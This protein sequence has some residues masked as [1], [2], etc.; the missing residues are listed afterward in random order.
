MRT[1]GVALAGA[2]AWSR[3]Y[4]NYHTPK[5]VGVGCVAGVVS[6]V[7]WFGITQVVRETGLLGW[8]LDTPLARAF[9]VRDLAVQEDMCQAGWEKWEEKR[10]EAASKKQ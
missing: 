8:A 6:A 10:S 1:A 2:T 3:I 7:G 9:R 4:V 5:Q